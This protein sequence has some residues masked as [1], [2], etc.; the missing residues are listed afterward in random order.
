MTE[1]SVTTPSE[2]MPGK[3]GGQLRRG[4]GRPPVS[5]AKQQALEFLRDHALDAARALVVKALR[6]D[7]RA[8]E[9]VLAYG[10][11]KP[12]DKLELSGPEGG[13]LELFEGFDDHERQ[14]LRD[15]ID[16]ELAAR[17]EADRGVAGDPVP[18]GAE[19]RE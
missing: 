7:T 13:P 4:G 11:G 16:A 14:A 17:Q 12:P 19:V 10:I 3:N 15:A 2:M 5:K 18:T 8:Q 6:G 9:L 1:T